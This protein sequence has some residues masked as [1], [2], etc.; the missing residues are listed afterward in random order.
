MVDVFKEG[1]T[2]DLWR[3]EGIVGRRENGR[4]RGREGGWEGGRKTGRK[5]GR[6]GG[7]ERPRLNNG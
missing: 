7:R 5:R 2:L 1:H 6:E 3:E 4:W